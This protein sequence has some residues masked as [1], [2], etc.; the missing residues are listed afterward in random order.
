MKAIFKGHYSYLQQRK[1]QKFYQQLKYLLTV[2]SQTGITGEKNN[3][4]QINDYG[5]KEY[6]DRSKSVNTEAV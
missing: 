1:N 5:N 3:Q 2:V 6:L 4:I